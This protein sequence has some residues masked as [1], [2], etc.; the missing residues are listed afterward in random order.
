MTPRRSPLS[1]VRIAD[2]TLHAAGPYCTHLLTLLGA[3]CIKI[4]TAGRLDIFR[5][6]HPVYGRLESATFDQ[7]S[8]GKLSIRLNLKHGEGLALARR[9]VQASDIV[10]ESFRPGVMQRL[11]LDYAALS[12]LKPGLVMVSVSAAGQYGPDSRHAGYAPVFG[13]AGG[14]GMLT[15]FEDGPP[16]EIRHAM[17]HSTGLN[18]AAATLAAWLRRKRTGQGSHVDVAAREVAMSFIGDALLQQ[19]LQGQAAGRAGNDMRPAAPHNV[20]P[21]REPDSWISIAVENDEHWRAL[22]AVMGQP[23]WSADPGYASQHARWH[24]RKALDG[25]VSAWTRDQDRHALAARLQA[26]GV[27]AF[28]SYTSADIVADPH[29]AERGVIQH[30]GPDRGGAQAPAGQA[31]VR[32]VVGAPWR[33]ERTPARACGHTPALG[34]HHDYVFGE[35]LGLS[36]ARIAELIEQKAIW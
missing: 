2:F 6:P 20:Y 17:D 8:A 36:S 7:V 23:D 15:G 11:G 25:H 21:C 1:G 30:Q 10:A 18:A 9:L 5:K 31:A 28:A 22:L 26:A 33:L 12:A 3:E 29:L 19:A 14:L 35:I 32:A 34:E 13:A 4:E 16:V 24:H 27:P